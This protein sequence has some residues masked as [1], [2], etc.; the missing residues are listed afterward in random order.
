MT[1]TPN[2]DYLREKVKRLNDLL[3]DP[4]PGLSTWIEAYGRVSREILDFWL[5]SLYEKGVIK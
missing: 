1:D 5:D 2:L 3:N 4:H